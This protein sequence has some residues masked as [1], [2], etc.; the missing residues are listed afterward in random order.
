MHRTTSPAGASLCG[1]TTASPRRS[2]SR[3][4][5]QLWGR[6]VGTA[7]PAGSSVV[8]YQPPA[9]NDTRPPGWGAAYHR[10]GGVVAAC[11]DQVR[12]RRAI[13]RPIRAVPSS[14]RLTGSGAGIGA[15]EVLAWKPTSEPPPSVTSQVDVREYGAASVWT[16]SVLSLLNELAV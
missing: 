8:A 13:P 12:R 1:R 6:K 7:R 5:V 11:R 4:L 15:R 3:S 16:T 10:P 2:L 9:P 14:V